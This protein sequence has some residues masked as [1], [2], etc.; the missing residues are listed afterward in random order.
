MTIRILLIDD[1][2][3]F[4][5]G[6]RLLLQRQPD[7]EVVAEA[8]DGV[9]GIKRAKEL[10]PDVVLLD[11]NLPGLSGL[12]TLQLLTQD[13]PNCAVIILTVSEEADELGQAL[14]DGARGYLVKNIDADALVSA[15]RRAAN[16]EAVIADSMTAK[17]VE[18]FRGQA[19]QTPPPPPGSAER[20]RLTARETQIVQWLARGA[21]N[22]VI[23][24]ELDVSESTVKIHVQNVLKKLNL[25]SR[26]QVAVY[27]VERGLYTEE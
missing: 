22:K 23:A 14:R 8:G 18:Q 1:H 21:S 27:A 4:R 12:E 7:F 6:V 2:T 17:L 16:G 9:E 11:L 13:L 19:S 26:V 10:K 24:R 15:I 3:L 25:T 5:S 20:H